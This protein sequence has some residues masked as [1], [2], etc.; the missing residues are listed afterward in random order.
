VGPNCDGSESTYK[1]EIRVIVRF[2]RAANLPVISYFL[3][4]RSMRDQRVLCTKHPNSAPASTTD[5]FLEVSRAWRSRRR[6]RRGAD[7]AGG[8]GAS[9]AI[10]EPQE[11]ELRARLPLQRRL[12][13]ADRRALGFRHPQGR[14][15]AVPVRLDVQRTLVRQDGVAARVRPKDGSVTSVSAVRGRAARR[16][17]RNPPLG[18]ALRALG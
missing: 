10:P 18:T 15:G 12:L 6:H 16:R 9:A 1:A 7:A 3:H 8:R 2:S 13:R 4:H 14:T 17:R 5:F 11:R